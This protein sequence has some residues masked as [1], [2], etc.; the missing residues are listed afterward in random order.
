[1]DIEENQQEDKSAPKNIHLM[2]EARVGVLIKALV[3]GN[4]H[5]CNIVR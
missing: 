2:I 5:K 3:C 4:K 1:M